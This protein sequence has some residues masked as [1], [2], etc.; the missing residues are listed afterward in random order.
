MSAEPTS[1]RRSLPSGW[2]FVVLGLTGFA[3]A[4]P[5]LSLAGS[6]P[7]LFVFARTDRLEIVLLAV[8]IAFVPPLAIG[9]LVARELHEP[10]VFRHFFA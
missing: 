2:P 10:E 3:I 6:N 8:G 9:G 1:E 7:A 5:L 4:Q